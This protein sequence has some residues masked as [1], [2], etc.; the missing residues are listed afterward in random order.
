MLSRLAF[1]LVMEVM[2]ESPTEQNNG[3]NQTLTR[4]CHGLRAA[5]LA[6]SAA[7]SLVAQSTQRGD[8]RP[9]LLLHRCTKTCKCLP[10]CLKM[11]SHCELF[12]AAC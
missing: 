12:E 4:Q 10:C 2:S 7:R 6:T 8:G 1:Q 11:Q 9:K 3:N 5:G